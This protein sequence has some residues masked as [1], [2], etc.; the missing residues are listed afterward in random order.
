VFVD[1]SAFYQEKKKAIS[2]LVSQKH[3]PYMEDSYIEIFNHDSFASLRGLNYVEKF[4][5]GGAFL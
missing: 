1:I 4:D 2:M 3:K 5:I